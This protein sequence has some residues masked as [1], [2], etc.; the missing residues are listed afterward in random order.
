MTVHNVMLRL[1]PALY[2]RLMEYALSNPN[3]IGA[4]G[5]RNGV[6]IAAAARDAIQAHLDFVDFVRRD[7]NAEPS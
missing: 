5:R 7:R 1:D 3:A 6:S 2:E 4:Q